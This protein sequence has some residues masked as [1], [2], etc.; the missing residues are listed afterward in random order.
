MAVEDWVRAAAILE[1]YVEQVDASSFIPDAVDALLKCKIRL[2]EPK[3]SLD[4]FIAEMK[5]KL[6]FHPIG[7]SLDSLRYRYEAGR[8]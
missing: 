4:A 2:N 1:A 7:Q 5:K 6:E 8:N 3:E